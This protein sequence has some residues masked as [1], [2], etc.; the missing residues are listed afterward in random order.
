MKRVE[1]K[2]AQMI[3]HEFQLTGTSKTSVVL[4]TLSLKRI[5]NIKKSL[6]KRRTIYLNWSEEFSLRGERTWRYSA[7]KAVNMWRYT[8]N[9]SATQTCKSHHCSAEAP[10]V[11]RK[12][13]AHVTWLS[14]R[15]KSTT[16]E[17]VHDL[18]CVAM[19][20]QISD[21]QCRMS[22]RFSPHQQLSA[23]NHMTLLRRDDESMSS[24]TEYAAKLFDRV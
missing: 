10:F 8:R 24:V 22:F 23:V 20:T 6:Q 12:A 18:V 5:N 7:S 13:A 2:S 9:K 21:P 16:C 4:S 15:L 3:K 1:S 11:T 17:P 19:V 14:T